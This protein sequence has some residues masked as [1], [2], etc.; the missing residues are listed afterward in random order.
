MAESLCVSSSVESDPFDDQIVPDQD[1]P[2]FVPTPPGAGQGISSPDTPPAQEV[3]GKILF[4]IFK[5]TLFYVHEHMS[6]HLLSLH[7]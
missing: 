3:M 2:F 7:V 6:K 1:D 4:S 5:L